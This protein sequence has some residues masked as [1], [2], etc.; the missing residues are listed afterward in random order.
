MVT[1]SNRRRQS[2]AG[3][4]AMAS[5]RTT[6]LAAGLLAMAVSLAPA[7]AEEADAP[8]LT[9]PYHGTA[10]SSRPFTLSLTIPWSYS[11]DV[12][13]RD[14]ERGASGKGDASTAPV[15]ALKWS[16]QLES[17]RLTASASVEIE[18]YLVLTSED[19]DIVETSGKLELTNGKSDFFVPY[20]T[21]RAQSLMEPLFRGP[22]D[23]RLD[24]QGGFTS[25]VGFRGGRVIDLGR[26]TRA[27]DRALELDVRAG[28]REG[29]RGSVEHW[30]TQARLKH[31]WVLTREL[32]FDMGPSVRRRWY[33]EE[34]RKD[35]RLAAVAELIWEPAWLTDVLPGSSI[36]FAVERVRNW[37][38]EPTSA[39]DYW[40]FGGQIKLSRRF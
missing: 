30:M 12:V 13:G 24:L 29:N 19:L 26:A 18:R 39:Y 10:S 21:Y 28:R 22:A 25:G 38:T 3:L 36:S 6:F 33:D 40:E 5:D 16:R 23:R 35:I 20:V 27:G 7:E 34:A 11:T 14:D 2:T 17:V 32:W 1:S 8:R 4:F 31:T 15:V 37:S 9:T